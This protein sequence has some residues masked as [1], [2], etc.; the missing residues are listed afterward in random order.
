MVRQVAASARGEQTATLLNDGTVL[1]AGGTTDPGTELYTP[2][3]GWT[4]AG[5]MITARS[6]QTATLMVRPRG[7]QRCLQLGHVELVPRSS[8]RITSNWPWALYSI[9]RAC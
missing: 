7:W 1:V 9:R 5:Q 2:E 4:S 6:E 3:A 8:S